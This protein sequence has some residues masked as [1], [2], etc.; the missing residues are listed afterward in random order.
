MNR[1]TS[2]YVFVPMAMAAAAAHAE[3]SPLTERGPADGFIEVMAGGPESAEGLGG[4]DCEGW[5]SRS[6]PS[7]VLDHA[8]S[9]GPLAV[10]VSEDGGVDTTLAVETPSGAWRCADDGHDHRPL[11]VIDEYELEAGEYRVHVGTYDL[12]DAGSPATLGIAE[13]NRDGWE[14]RDPDTTLPTGFAGADPVE[15]SAI[16]G[17]F[18]DASTLRTG[19]CVGYVSSGSPDYAF[20]WEGPAGS[21]VRLLVESEVDTTLVVQTPSGEWLCDD[22]SGPDVNQPAIDVRS[23]EEGTYQV[24][25]GTY[26]LVDFGSEAAFAIHQGIS[27]GDAPLHGLELVSSGTGFVVSG[28]GHVLT[29]EHMVDGCDA[30]TVGRNARSAAE[31]R[32][33]A[34]NGGADLAILQFDA[35]HWTSVAVFRSNLPLR[36]GEEIAVLGFPGDENHGPTF[37][38]GVISNLIGFEGGLQELQHNAEIRD[39]SSG[40]PIV[41]RAGHVVGIVTGSL[42]NGSGDGDAPVNVGY[43]TRGSVA[44]AFLQAHAVPFEQAVS[45]VEL[46]WPDI[47]EAL[48]SHTVIVRCYE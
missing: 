37:T 20:A 12:R 41:D 45:E 48:I 14:S 26:H 39:G 29:N 44:Q 22:D 33:V 43:G 28:A 6:D 18:T 31:A 9:G 2:S 27:D 11:L 5:I 40:S 47:A 15:T 1:M 19:D 35:Q 17:G 13:L 4:Y 10:L 7:F 24:W 21:G 42:S 34:T 3:V 8:G 38:T 32:V 46:S 16:A 23:L 36:L 30:L 25:I